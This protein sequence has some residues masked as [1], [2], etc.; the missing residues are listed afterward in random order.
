MVIEALGP[1]LLKVL[2]ERKFSGM[3]LDLIQSVL[4]DILSALVALASL[5]LI[6][7]DV[8]PENILLQN[9]VSEQVKL[10]DFGQVCSCDD[11]YTSYVQSRFYRSPE[12]ILQI[13][14]DSKIDVWSLGCVAAELMLGLP[15]FP[16]QSQA[17]LIYLINKM[18]GP[19]QKEYIELSP[20]KE[21]Y[22]LPDGTIKSGDQLGKE[23]NEDFESYVQ[24]FRHK[25]LD[26]IIMSYPMR[27]DASENYVMKET[28]YRSLFVDLLNKML[29]LNP[30]ERISAADALKEPF[31]QMDFKNDG[32]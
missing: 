7:C 2:K 28:H 15:I 21:L 8:K 14:Y 20:V 9:M 19:F 22:F 27:P 12:V 11:A 13:P 30:K 29:K 18:L 3:G 31:M 4:K 26:E 23:N 32:Y 5:E 6:H 25:Q 10:I 17:H 1:S 24:Y 16:A